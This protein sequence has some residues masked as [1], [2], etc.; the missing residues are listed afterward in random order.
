MNERF[1]SYVSS[2]Q[3]LA[4]AKGVLW[5]IPVNPDGSIEKSIAWNLTQ[6]AGATPP[7]TVWLRQLGADAN[8][9]KYLNEKRAADGLPLIESKALS[10]GWQNL[11][12]AAV[13]DRIYVSRNQP[14]PVANAVVRPLKALATC[15]QNAE[16]WEL[17]RD[18]LELAHEIAGKVQKSGKLADDII[19]II[20]K[21]IDANL[22]ADRCPLSS[23]NKQRREH[24]R[25]S[26]VVRRRLEER[27][28]AQKLPTERAFWEAVRIAWTEAPQ[29]FF[30]L[31][32]FAM[33]RVLVMCGFRGNEASRI[34]LDWKRWREYTD[35]H[36]RN[37]GEAGGIGRSLMLRNFAEK[38]RVVGADSI[39]LYE[40][41]Q[42]IPKE[43]ETPLIETLDEIVDKTAPLRRRLQKQIETGRVFPQFRQDQLIPITEVYTLLTG[44]P[45]V[46]EDE[47]R[48]DYIARYRESLDTSIFTE[49]KERQAHLKCLGAPLV[50][51][52]RI[53][54][55]NRL[56]TGIGQQAP[57][58]DC[59]GTKR[60]ELRR[61][62]VD[63]SSDKFLIGELEEFLQKAIPTKLSDVEPFRFT[64]GSLLNASDMLFLAP[65]RALAEERNDGICDV[66]RYAF[67]GRVTLADLVCSL[68][69]SGKL[70][71]IFEKYGNTDDTRSLSLGSH[72]FRHLQNTELFRLGVADTIITKRFNRHSVAQSHDYDHRTLAEDL[73]AIDVPEVAE[74]LL[75]GKAREVFKL[76]S[77]DKVHGPIV[78][79]FKRIQAEEGDEAAFVF[80]ATEA[81]GFHTTPYGHCINSFTVE[82]CPKALECFNGCRHLTASGLPEHTRNLKALRKRYKT[83]LESIEGHPAPSGSKQNMR[84]HAEQR[85]DAIERILNSSPGETVFPDGDVH[86]DPIKEKR[87]GPF[88]ETAR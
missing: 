50:N 22:L 1:R 63:Y 65:K 51:K 25:N 47:E 74:P 5:D 6:M 58:R 32:K 3:D 67:V 84:L 13:I 9:L 81:D 11:I 21:L 4:Q 2:A 16:P 73:A 64:D 88:N 59:N 35:T 8:T 61:K 29:S 40:T 66:T 26:K 48:D 17:T 42:H 57:F 37:A 71:S 60:S 55:G 31:Q 33:I 20:R 28:E 39:A 45:F 7:P 76:I 75:T 69:S 62:R 49:I 70:P 10:V 44:E 82:P 78:D 41:A 52:V 46:Y 83:L 12:K 15:A 36:G 68:S 27:Q 77:A 19:G 14:E 24:P 43:F 86:L 79:E 85:L 30:D 56:G 53:Y 23:K 18:H 54:L 34:P 72:Q 87:T 38:Q 80:L